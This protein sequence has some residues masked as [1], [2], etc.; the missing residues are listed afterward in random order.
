MKCLHCPF[1]IDIG[2]YEYPEMNCPFFGYD[3]PDEFDNEDHE[4]CNLRFSEAK[5]LARL[6]VDEWEYTPEYHFKEMV[7]KDYKP[8]EEDLAEEKELQE[9]RKKR[10]AL[11]NEYFEVLKA[12]RKKEKQK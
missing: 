10:E 11:Y 6:Q 7:D 4:G 12:R 1:A 3:V 8:T 9:K 2:T 5:K